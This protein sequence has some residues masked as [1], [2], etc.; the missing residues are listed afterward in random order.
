MPNRQNPSTKLNLSIAHRWQRRK[1]T[2]ANRQIKWQW[3]WDRVM[4]SK[5]SKSK[6]KGDSNNNVV[7]K[8]LLIRMKWMNFFCSQFQCIAKCIAGI[9]NRKSITFH[10]KKESKI[11]FH[12][13]FVETMQMPFDISI[14]HSLIWIDMHFMNSKLSHYTICLRLLWL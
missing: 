5:N 1:Q 9:L 12:S 14:P 11:R 4:K 13:D 8:P 2:A 10:Q 3:D 7:N 6:S